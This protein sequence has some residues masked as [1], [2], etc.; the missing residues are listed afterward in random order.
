MTDDRVSTEDTVLPPH[1]DIRAAINDPARYVARGWDE[2]RGH[3]YVG[4]W[5]ARAVEELL[6]RWLAGR[7]VVAPPDCV[8]TPARCVV[9]HQEECDLHDFQREAVVEAL[10]DFQ[11]L[12]GEDTSWAGLADTAMETL[13]GSVSGEVQPDA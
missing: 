1:A 9:I 13:A 2:E 12:C 4:S 6:R 11:A 8:C 7:V 10:D 5:S 3:E